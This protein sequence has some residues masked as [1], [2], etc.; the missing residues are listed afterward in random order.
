M[1]R[2]QLHEDFVNKPSHYLQMA[3]DQKLPIEDLFNR[4]APEKATRYPD[5]AFT[6]FLARENLVI[7][8]TR[9]EGT[10]KVQEFMANDARRVAFWTI[11]DRDYENALGLPQL[12]EKMVQRDTNTSDPNFNSPFNPAATRP[13][14]ERHKFMPKITINDIAAG[15]ETIPGIS[16]QQ[17]EY[18]TTMEKEQTGDLAEGEPI[19]TTTVSSGTVPGKTKKFGGGLRFTDEFALEAINM[20]LLRI[21]ARRQAMRDE[22]KIV[23]DG[24]L[25]A[26]RAAGATH[27]LDLGTGV[28]TFD[29]LLELALFDGPESAAQN[30]NEDN[31]YQL[32]TLFTNR[33]LA[34]RLMTSYSTVDN[35]G[36]FSQYPA[37]RFGDFWNPIQLINS[38]LG[39]PTRLGIVRNGAVSSTTPTVAIDDE[40]ALGID[41]RYALILQ[42]QA[43]GITTEEMRIAKEQVT[44]RYTTQRVGWLVAD[45]DACFNI[46]A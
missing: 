29:D 12:E 42:R 7:S 4:V 39:G 15:S 31:G 32:L 5:D 2:E 37:D 21:F 16:F 17:P 46:G 8:A 26:L 11:L 10:A 22:I 30:P 36:V 23:N 20:G 9:T 14:Y 18:Q 25:A 24:L 40:N 44:E 3:K 35:P 1:T 45:P 27:D 34:K 19:P 6:D 33:A 13:L 43:R 38:G 41:V 28:I